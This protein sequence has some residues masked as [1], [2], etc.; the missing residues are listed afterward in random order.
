MAQDNT[1]NSL[2]G[3]V[4]IYGAS[5]FLKISL[6]FIAFIFIL[7]FNALLIVQYFSNGPVEKPDTVVL[8]TDAIL[9]L[10][11][12]CLLFALFKY[13]IEI[14]PD[15]IKRVSIL[16]KTELPINQIQGFRAGTFHNS[17]VLIIYP[18]NPGDAEIKIRD[19]GGSKKD[20][21]KW[22]RQNLTD[23]NA[24]DY[25]ADMDSIK[26]DKSLGDTQEQRMALVQ[27]AQIASKVLNSFAIV[28][29]LWGIYFPY[30]QRLLFPVLLILPVISLGLVY[31]FRGALKFFVQ[32]TK[33]AYSSIAIAFLFPVYVM[34]IR[35]SSEFNI[36]KWEGFW[37]QFFLLTLVF[38]VMALYL[39]SEIKQKKYLILLFVIGCAAYSY[40]AIISL[41]CILDTSVPRTYKAQIMNKRISSGRNTKYYIT[42]SPW[43]LKN[44]V[45]GIKV[46]QDVYDR[47]NTKENVDVITRKGRFDIPWFYIQ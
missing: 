47:H 9:T 37:F 4:Q 45:S 29:S 24:A 34:T 31:Y 13:R 10:L 21:E 3:P 27:R 11:C 41:N 25:Q 8:I 36:L 23:L 40:A 5:V 42:L 18:K 7:G 44:E 17:T 46:E 26:Q 15:K 33:G 32:R 35:T 1:T 22:I 6:T 2:S 12:L 16:R 20:L 30:P 43:E 19:L 28:L 14:Y 39:V 38:I